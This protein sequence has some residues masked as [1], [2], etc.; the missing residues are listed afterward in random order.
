M[1]RKAKVKVVTG[2]CPIPAHPRSLDDYGAL[3]ERLKSALGVRP[4]QAFHFGMH[5]LWLTQFLERQEPMKP[6]LSWA[7]ADNPAKNTLEYHCVQHQKVE[8]LALAATMDQEADTFVWVDFGI[9]HLPDMTSDYFTT[10]LD[11]IV[12][13]DFAV[14]GCWTKDDKRIE[15]VGDEHPNWRFCGGLWIVPRDDILNLVKAFKAVDRTYIR[16]KKKVT[17]EVNVLAYVEQANIPNLRWY[18]A[19]HNP[20]MFTHYEPK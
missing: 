4:A 7:K 1:A 5:D 18:A 13:N 12:K 8:W 20:T 3:G 16:L 9:M 6:P 2:F 15:L 19:D 14:P 17:F 11:K 10:F